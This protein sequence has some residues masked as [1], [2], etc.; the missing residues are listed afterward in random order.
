M[1]K[2][3]PKRILYVPDATLASDS[4]YKIGRSFVQLKAYNCK[5]EPWKF[6]P[7]EQDILK[8]VRENPPDILLAPWRLYLDWK[9]IEGEFGFS[10]VHGPTFCGYFTKPIKS[11]QIINQLDERRALLIDFYRLLP[12]EAALLL[13]TLAHPECRSSVCHHFKEDT[14]IFYEDW[15]ENEGLTHRADLISGILDQ[16]QPEWI[17]RMHA[18]RICL[19]SFWSLVFDYGPGKENVFRSSTHPNSKKARLEFAADS[20]HLMFKIT[21]EKPSQ[22]SSYSFKQFWLDQLDATHPAQMLLRFS[23]A[24]EVHTVSESE[25]IEIKI[26]FFFSNSA[27][28]DFSSLKTAFLEPISNTSVNVGKSEGNFIEYQK[29]KPEV[30]DRSAEKEEAQKELFQKQIANTNQLI[31]TLKEE[32]NTLKDKIAEY[33]LGGVGLKNLYSKEDIKSVVTLFQNEL[34]KIAKEIDDVKEI[35]HKIHQTEGIPFH[36]IHPLHLKVQQAQSAHLSISEKLN[37]LLARLVDAKKAG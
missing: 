3:S 2:L 11:E 34:Q 16:I 32:I 28:K 8:A 22:Y 10:R 25:Q 19:F 27:S 18:I 31:D 36:I 6:K 30:I 13:S 17:V 26:H 9:K 12:Q 5:V 33:K 35:T 1:K 7:T 15:Y 14:P 37:G 29:K 4:R 21:F 23:D 24:V 20:V